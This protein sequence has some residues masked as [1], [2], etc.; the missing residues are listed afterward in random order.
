MGEG[1]TPERP[2][3][4]PSLE[5]VCIWVFVT[6]RLF[7]ASLGTAF[8]VAGVFADGIERERAA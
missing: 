2:A 7:G 4:L 5:R 8:K 6:C 3:D 1:T